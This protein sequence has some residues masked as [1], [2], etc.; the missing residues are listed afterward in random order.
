MDGRAPVCYFCKGDVDDPEAIEGAFIRVRTFFK[1][2]PVLGEFQEKV[3]RKTNVI[4]E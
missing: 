4:L 2:I 3:L 1:S